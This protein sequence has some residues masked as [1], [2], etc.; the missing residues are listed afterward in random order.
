[1][2]GTHPDRQGI[3]ATVARQQSVSR[4]IV[5]LRLRYT[6]RPAILARQNPPWRPTARIAPSRKPSMVL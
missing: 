5:S 3:L 1:V 4:C 2:M 6:G